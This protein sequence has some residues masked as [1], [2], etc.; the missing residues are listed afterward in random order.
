M[1]PSEIINLLR[2][3]KKYNHEKHDYITIIRDC[4]FDL[5]IVNHLTNNFDQESET[6]IKLCYIIADYLEK[7]MDENIVEKNRSEKINNERIN[8]ILNFVFKKTISKK[9]KNKI[10]SKNNTRLH[11]CPHCKRDNVKSLVFIQDKQYSCSN[12]HKF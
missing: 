9:D 7:M 3:H 5:K 1:D 10:K 2:K 8:D 6:I 4:A 12:G 11:H